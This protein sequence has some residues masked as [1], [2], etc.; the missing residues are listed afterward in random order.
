MHIE[1]LGYHKSSMPKIV[2]LVGD[3][4]V[5]DYSWLDP[6]PYPV[7]VTNEAYTK[8]QRRKQK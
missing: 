1:I 6:P 3:L 7:T 8:S 2:R 5:F 4:R